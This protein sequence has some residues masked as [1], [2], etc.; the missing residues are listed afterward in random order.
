M[1]KKVIAYF[2]LLAATTL[3][4]V[5]CSEDTALNNDVSKRWQ[6]VINGQVDAQQNWVTAI[7][8]Q[9][10]IL[11]KNGSTVKALVERSLFCSARKT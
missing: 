2:P 6:E 4:M 10:D 9:L 1:K 7:D 5:S 3:G 11:A 8:M